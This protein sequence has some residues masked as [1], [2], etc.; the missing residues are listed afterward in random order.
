LRQ[1]DQHIQNAEIAF[2]ERHLKR[3]HIQP[4][5]RKH[6]AMIAPARICRRAPAPRVRSIDDIIVN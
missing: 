2:F 4:V 3:L 1:V 6:A 5:S